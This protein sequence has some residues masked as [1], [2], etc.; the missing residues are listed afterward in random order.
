[1][2]FDKLKIMKENRDHTIKQVLSRMYAIRDITIPVGGASGDTILTLD[3]LSE[4]LSQSN[5]SAKL[6]GFA[7][8]R[9]N[10]IVTIITRTLT[11]TS[12]GLIASFY[13]QL[14]NLASRSQNVLQASQTPNK[15]V[16]V[17]GSEGIKLKIP[18]ISPFY[19]KNLISG[20]GDIG[21]VVLKLLTSININPVKVRVFIQAD[22]DDISVEYPTFATGP[23]RQRQIERM[24]AKLQIEQRRLINA[25]NENNLMRVNEEQLAREVLD[26]M[27]LPDVVPR[28]QVHMKKAPHQRTI[29]V[30]WQPAMNHINKNGEDVTHSLALSSKNEL[31]MKENQYG[32]GMNEM[33]ISHIAKS[34][35]IIAIPR[36]TTSMVAGT[37]VYARPCSIVDATSNDGEISITHQTWAAMTCQKWKADLEFALELYLNPF[38]SVT[39][40]TIFNPC[41]TGEYAIND[42]INFDKVNLPNRLIIEFDGQNTQSMHEVKPAA[43]NAIKNVPTARLGTVTATILSWINDCFS[44]ECSY[45]MFYVAIE[46][47]L[48]AI[49]S[50]APFVDYTVDFSTKDLLL[51]DRSEYIPLVPSVHCIKDKPKVHMMKTGLTSGT[52]VVAKQPTR[53]DNFETNM[54]ASEN[55]LDTNDVCTIEEC[56]G[57]SFT[58]IKEMLGVFTP[59]CP[60]ITV[61]AGNALLI[62]PYIFRAL[63]D[64]SAGDKFKFHD[65]FD[66]FSAGYAYYQGKINMRIGKITDQQAPFGEVMTTTRRNPVANFGS[67]SGTGLVS[68][69]APNAAK[70]GSSVVPL[71]KEECIPQLTVPYYQPFHMARIT[72]SNSYNSANQPKLTVWRP[73]NTE[74]VRLSRAIDSDFSFGFLTALPTFQLVSGSM[75]A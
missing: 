48:I 2:D 1:L 45:G 15:R 39:L 30:K 46:V 66:Y 24:M 22:I 27:N 25:V 31:R 9:T 6:E 67:T 57:D 35:Q 12:G 7:F 3:L 68:F 17:S 38:H 54:T 28:P 58:N 26:R 55:A 23:L 49:N 61:D 51:S 21:N 20:S 16:S 50:V 52:A 41:D 32:T 65:W 37:V 47:P 73:Y 60:V 14:T 56:L 74:T 69:A 75:F 44:E 33:M 53:S 19:G 29:S 10:F 18:F 40:T 42:V 59:F 5:V 34:K 62:E 70:S 43:N 64:L 4:F 71:Y 72:N 36:I 11:T 63:S 13:P 8:L